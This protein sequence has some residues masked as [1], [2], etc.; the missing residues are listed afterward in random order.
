MAPWP[1]TISQRNAHIPFQMIIQ[2]LVQQIFIEHLLCF[3]ISF[4][5]WET[6]VNKIPILRKFPF[7]HKRNATNMLSTAI[8]APIKGLLASTCSVLWCLLPSHSEFG[9][10]SWLTL[11]SRTQWND[12]ASSKSRSQEAWRASALHLLRPYYCHENSLSEPA[13]G[14]KPTGRKAR[15]VQLTTTHSPE[16]EPSSSQWAHKGSS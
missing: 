13:G 14:W 10:F 6:V 4:R 16:A 3:H 9:L 12:S 15:T 7:H 1:S 11:A 2:P 8:M 5:D